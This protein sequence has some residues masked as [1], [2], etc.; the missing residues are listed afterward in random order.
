MEEPEIRTPQDP[1][2]HIEDWQSI[3]ETPLHQVQPVLDMTPTENSQ[4]QDR[5]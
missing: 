4:L 3:S 1:L 2:T 5:N